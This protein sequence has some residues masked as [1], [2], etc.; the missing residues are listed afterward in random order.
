MTRIRSLL[1]RMMMSISR[2]ALR[3]S[4]RLNPPTPET[5]L[6]GYVVIWNQWERESD[7]SS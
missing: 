4:Q 1:S 5:F 2:A 7:I 6:K 3:T